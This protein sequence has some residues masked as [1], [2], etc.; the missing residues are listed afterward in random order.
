MPSSPVFREYI[1]DSVPASGVHSGTGFKIE[2]RSVG[3]VLV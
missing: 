1:E 2:D 3:T